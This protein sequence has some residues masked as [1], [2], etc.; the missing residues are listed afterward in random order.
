MQTFTKWTDEEEGWEHAGDG[1]G[2]TEAGP[3]SE[4]SGGGG[5]SDREK[6]RL[7]RGPKP[8][9]AAPGREVA[10]FPL[11]GSRAP[12]EP[13][14]GL[15]GSGEQTPPEAG[16]AESPE[17]TRGSERNRAGEAAGPTPR[18]WVASVPALLDLRVPLEF[19]QIQLLGHKAL[20]SRRGHR[21]SS[22]SG[23]ELRA[24]GGRA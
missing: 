9:R 13:R 4:S 19:Q 2:G 7:P 8:G 11:G 21:C 3:R 17:A 20:H 10:R 12:P 22:A 23:P 16:Q 15:G 24:S 14:S 5:I 1:T 6:N 18:V